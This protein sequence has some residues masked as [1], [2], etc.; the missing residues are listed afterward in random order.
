MSSN[1]VTSY[2]VAGSAGSRLQGLAARSRSQTVMKPLLMSS[3]LPQAAGV[4][5][6]KGFSQTMKTM[7]PAYDERAVRPCSQ[8]VKK[9]KPDVIHASALQSAVSFAAVLKAEGHTGNVV[10][11]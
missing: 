3:S 9:A 4:L 1:F 2:R 8:A 7:Q 5:A 10:V 11:S 6:V